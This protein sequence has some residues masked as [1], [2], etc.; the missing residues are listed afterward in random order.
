V[1]WTDTRQGASHRGLCHAPPIQGGVQPHCNLGAAAD[2][3]SRHNGLQMCS[4]QGNEG[5]MNNMQLKC[6][7]TP[8]A[9][10]SSQPSPSSQFSFGTP[11]S[12]TTFIHHIISFI[13]ITAMA[14]SIRSDLNSIPLSPKS[15]TWSRWSLDSEDIQRHC[16]DHV[17]PTSGLR[18]WSLSQSMFVSTLPSLPSLHITSSVSDPSASVG[19]YASTPPKRHRTINIT[20]NP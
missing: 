2:E 8:H 15:P 1:R 13:L 16:H 17:I 4:H 18:Y 12:L 3:E 9:S 5:K 20:P 10:I 11:Y 7:K 14:S 6:H 19:P